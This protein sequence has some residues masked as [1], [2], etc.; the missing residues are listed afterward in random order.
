MKNIKKI[1]RILALFIGILQ[2]FGGL[3]GFTAIFR[4]PLSYIFWN[5]VYIVIMFGFFVFSIISGIYLIKD[6]TFKK[7]IK[8]S[9][10][11]QSIQILQF[12]VLGLG[13]YYVAGPYIGLGFIDTPNLHFITDFAIFRS[14]SS[15]SLFSKSDEISLSFN[16]AAIIIV[17]FLFY[18]DDFVEVK[19]KN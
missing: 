3:L 13:L 14:Y 1:S 12:Q 7:G 5:F 11:N 10:I 9:I 6:N 15:I 17:L 19:K 16:L 4:L 8:L 2:V 18:I